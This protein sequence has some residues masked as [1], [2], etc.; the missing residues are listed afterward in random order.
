MFH[1]FLVVASTLFVG[2]SSDGLAHH[3]VE[4]PFAPVLLSSLDHF[5][6]F[7]EEANISLVFLLIPVRSGEFFVVG[8]SG[9]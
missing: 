1:H 7:Y 2:S 4:V 3:S 8:V 6:E 5:F 9:L